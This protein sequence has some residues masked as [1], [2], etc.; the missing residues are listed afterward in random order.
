MPGGQKSVIY[1]KRRID[2]LVRSDG[3]I[4]EDLFSPRELELLDIIDSLEER[5]K[6]I[7]EKAKK[8]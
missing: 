1:T 4:S 3:E 2:K 8:E 7:E 5:I 6:V